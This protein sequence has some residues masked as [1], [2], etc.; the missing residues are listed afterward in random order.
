MY[1]AQGQGSLG[2]YT[3]NNT[4]ALR[5]FNP[6]FGRQVKYSF[7]L[8]NFSSVR[9]AEHFCLSVYP[10][11]TTDFLT[12]QSFENIVNATIDIYDVAGNIVFSKKQD[13]ADNSIIEIDVSHLLTGSY[14]VR[15]SGGKRSSWGSF[16]KK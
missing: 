10:N 1:Q 13:F 7:V 2:F 11:P 9:E 12:I 6:D 16:V 3:N 14:S 4:Q 5:I 15:I 8:N